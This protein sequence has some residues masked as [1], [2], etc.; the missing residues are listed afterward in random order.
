MAKIIKK[1]VYNGFFYG[2]GFPGMT[3]NLQYRG[4]SLGA[5]TDSYASAVASMQFTDMYVGDTFTQNGHTYKIGGLNY[6]FGADHNSDLP[7]HLLMITDILTKREMNPTPTT[8]GGFAGSEMWKS[9]FP[10][11]VN[12]LK[13]D[14]GSH[15]LTW[16]EYLTTGTATSADGAADQGD[17]FPVQASMMNRVMY[18]GTLNSASSLSTPFHGKNYNIGIE[19]KQLPIMKLHPK[20]ITYGN[21]VWQRDIFDKEGFNTMNKTFQ[22][23]RDW[24]KADNDE[25]GVRAFFLIG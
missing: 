18:C 6:L 21:S 23:T 1:I 17:F 24:E 15:L 22:A 25:V 14:F 4:K 9:Y 11:V 2:L 3:H 5:F 13:A 16:N 20:E 10:T 12:Q 19:T 8:S 7:P